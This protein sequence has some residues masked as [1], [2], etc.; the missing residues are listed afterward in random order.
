MTRPLAHDAAFAALEAA[1]LEAL[2]DDERRDVLAHVEGCAECRA[3]LDELRESVALLA[4]A[5]PD[6]RLEA[7]RRAAIRSRLLSRVA[8]DAAPA[9]TTEIVD[10]RVLHGRRE[11]LALAA[12]IVALAALA[13]GASFWRERNALRN[14][15]AATS[16]RDSTLTRTVDSLRR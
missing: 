1:A 4:Y 11:W 7:T 16:A 5:A 14:V 9:V 8:A 3:A 6:S 13:A 2:G 10:I 12:S 15:V